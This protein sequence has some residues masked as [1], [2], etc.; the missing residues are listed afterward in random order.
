MK[1]KFIY[2]I[3]LSFLI[4]CNAK[5]EIHI[6]Y[7]V[8]KAMVDTAENKQLIN[9]TKMA[10]NNFNTKH[11]NFEILL[12][13]KYLDNENNNYKAEVE[14]IILNNKVKIIFSEGSQ[15]TRSLE[16]LINLNEV[17][18]INSLNDTGV[19]NQLNPST[20]FSYKSI[21]G[22]YKKLVDTIIDKNNKTYIFY[23]FKSDLDEEYQYITKALSLKNIEYKSFNINGDQYLN[24]LRDKI[25]NISEDYNFKESF[26]SYVFLGFN[27]KK[28]LIINLKQKKINGDYFC[29]SEF[30]NEDEQ[31]LESTKYL[32]GVIFPYITNQDGTEFVL[33]E[34]NSDYNY[35]Y[36]NDVNNNFTAILNYDTVGIVLESIIEISKNKRRDSNFIF[37]LRKHLLDV[38]DYTGITGKVNLNNT[39]KINDYIFPCYQIQTNGTIKRID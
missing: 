3:F 8:N 22:T 28:E 4:A 2:I 29:D 15:L 26:N 30:L 24:A 16:K 35:N 6:A 34:F 25:F 14:D 21:N 32:E 33:E 38:S 27:K 31:Y 17:L 10:V 11:K 20:L 39:Q 7:V 23:N 5:K 13:L 18:L 36:I 19:L 9:S 37:N 1:I 12:H